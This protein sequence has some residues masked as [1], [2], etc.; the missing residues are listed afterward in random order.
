ARFFQFEQLGTTYR[1]EILAGVTTFIT[2]AYTLVVTPSILSN[3]IFLQ[4]PGDLFDELVVATAIVSAISTLL[5]GCWTNYPVALAPGMG[6]N[7]L[8]AFSVVLDLKLDW[9]LALMAA[10]LQGLLFMGLCVSGLRDRLINAIPLSLKHAIVAGIG[11]F[12]AYIALSGNPTSPTLGAGIIV[13]SDATKTTLGSLSNPVTL[14]A[15]FG[16]LF[17]AAL[18]VRRV[19]G[20]MLWGILATAGLGWVF[21]IA[22]APKGLMAMPHFPVH[23]F[24]QAFTGFHYFTPDQTANLIAAM[25]ILLFV[26]LFDSIGALMGLGQQAGSLNSKG[27]LTRSSQSLVAIGAGTTVGSLLGIS[28]VAPYL[29]SAAGISEGGRSGFSSII[30]SALLLVSV[31]FLPL[32]AAVPAFAT[33]PV[34]ILVGV[35]MVGGS[36]KSIDWNDHAEA[37][38]AFLMML[39]MP[40]SFSLADGIAIGFITYPLLKVFQGRA[41]EIDRSLLVLAFLSV[42]FLVLMTGQKG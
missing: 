10:L 21:K 22:P 42:L 5:M 32:L 9:R 36:V 40:L 14:L 18:M 7:S 8:F 1:T 13:A 3:A 17:T 19:K 29:E 11:L 33:A 12:M 41:R 38:P 27:E 30:V 37:I 2:L 15:V 25:F 39:I 28:P 4:Q 20:G 31:L 6:L 23:L 16:L 24:G 26:T 34:L 35:L